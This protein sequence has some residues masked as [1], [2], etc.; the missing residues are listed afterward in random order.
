MSMPYKY[1]GECPPNPKLTR[2]EREAQLLPLCLTSEGKSILK[3]LRH[4]AE[5]VPVGTEPFG[6]RGVFMESYVE[7][8]LR[9][10]YPD[11]APPK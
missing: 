1:A 8:I 6:W 11:Q 5:G 3:N 2:H 7:A 10:E 4:A 9:I